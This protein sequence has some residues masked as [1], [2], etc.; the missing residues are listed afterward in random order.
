M[1]R[2][3]V[4]LAASIAVMLAGLLCLQL[5]KLLPF[6]LPPVPEFVSWLLFVS[7]LGLIA[8]AEAA[9]LIRG[10]ASGAPSDPIKHLVMTGIYRWV[11]NPIYLGGAL[12]LMG[13]SLARQSPTLLLAAILFL[14]VMHVTVVR[15]E[16]SRLER[17]FGG[18][19]LEYKLRVR[20]WIPRPPNK[21]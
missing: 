21:G 6:A 9:F 4:N 11:R 1:K 15:A 12:V 3:L 8:L 17:D 10:G 16:E 5:D 20:R 2:I 7:G 19:Y 13:V 14:P 18:A